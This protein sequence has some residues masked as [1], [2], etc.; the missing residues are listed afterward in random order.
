MQACDSTIKMLQYQYNQVKEAGMPND[1]PTDP[2]ATVPM[3]SGAIRDVLGN[4]ISIYHRSSDAA[5]NFPISMA[6]DA[7]FA[8]HTQAM[9]QPDNTH[10]DEH[11]EMLIK[12]VVYDALNALGLGAVKGEVVGKAEIWDM[13]AESLSQYRNEHPIPVPTDEYIKGLAWGMICERL[14]GVKGELKG[15]TQ[16][17]QMIDEAI[18]EHTYGETPPPTKKE[19]PPHAVSQIQGMIDASIKAA[20]DAALPNALAFIQST[21]N[22]MLAVH[23]AEVLEP[24][25]KASVGIQGIGEIID[26]WGK[27]NLSPEM[28]EAMRGLVEQGINQ[29]NRHSALT[30]KIVNLAN[31]TLD[32]R[33]AAQD[34]DRLQDLYCAPPQA[35]PTVETQVDTR[36]RE[37]LGESTVIID[38][39]MPK[40][41]QI[42]EFIDAM[43]GR[44]LVRRYAI[45][46]TESGNDFV[47]L[48]YI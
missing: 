15:H 2:I 32:A 3:M 47:T 43:V 25:Q 24:L 4:H 16:I 41:I 46:K 23:S 29:Y 44:G 35:E 14:D 20:Q 42:D 22:D 12:G 27:G 37:W 10:D 13:I 33:L 45:G 5:A 17:Q 30:A 19:I 40:S 34:A 1:I 48:E 6:I 26:D 9:H 38:E 18:K 11:H 36:L 7:A 8:E 21:V 39:S 28:F 31:D